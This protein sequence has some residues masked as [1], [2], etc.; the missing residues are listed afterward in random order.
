M[1]SEFRVTVSEYKHQSFHFED[2]WSILVLTQEIKSL[3][4]VAVLYLVTVEKS[5]QEGNSYCVSKIIS[6]L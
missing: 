3:D 4:L 2:F 5:G 6:G 1:T